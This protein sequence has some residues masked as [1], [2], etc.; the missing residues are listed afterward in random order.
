MEELHRAKYGVGHGASIYSL[1]ASHPQHL[2]LFTNLEVLKT[3]SFLG[4]Y[5]GI[6][7]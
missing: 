4:F 7:T 2:H 1:G 3:P 6:I 5:G